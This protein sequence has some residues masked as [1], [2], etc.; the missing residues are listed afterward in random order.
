MGLPAR[1]VTFKFVVVFY[2]LSIKYQ[3]FTTR[4]NDGM[5]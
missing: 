5:G 4:K 1:S 3:Y 2:I